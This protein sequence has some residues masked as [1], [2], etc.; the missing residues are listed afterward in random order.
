[1]EVLT[2]LIPVSLIL[3]LLGL[4]AFIW[5]LRKGMYDDPDGDSQRILT[6]EYDDKPK[7]VDKNG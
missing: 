4:G 5:T 2:I 7:P 3:G 1:M 6:D